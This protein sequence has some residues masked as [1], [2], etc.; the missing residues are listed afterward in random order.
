M[1]PYF[2]I[3]KGV[4][5][6]NQQ[7]HMKHAAKITKMIIKWDFLSPEWKAIQE[8]VEHIIELAIKDMLFTRDFH[9]NW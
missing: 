9:T 4:S 6:L 3:I 1:E 8:N 2:K 5:Y 7:K